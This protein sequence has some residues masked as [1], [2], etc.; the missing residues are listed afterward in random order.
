[1]R[2]RERGGVA[3]VVVGVAGVARRS[4]F[5]FVE[6]GPCLFSWVDAMARKQGMRGSPVHEHPC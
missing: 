2:G 6:N 1:V 5:V 3:A 4:A